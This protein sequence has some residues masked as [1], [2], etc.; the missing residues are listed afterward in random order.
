MKKD[1]T[2]SETTAWRLIKRRSVWLFVGFFIALFLFAVPNLQEKLA[3][4]TQAQR[5]ATWTHAS[6]ALSALIHEL[7]KERGLSSGYLASNGATFSDLMQQQRLL[8]DHALSTALA[9]VLRTVDNTAGRN[10]LL[11]LN[12]LRELINTQLI[13]RDAQVDRY[14]HMINLL[15][16]H[17]AKTLTSTTTPWPS[18]L[19]FMAFLRAKDMMGLE[20]SLL[21]TIL[22]SRDFGSYARIA[23]FHRI[24]A[25]QATHI[26]QFLQFAEPDA[27]AGYQDILK[28]AFMDQAQGIR[29]HVIAAGH[30]GASDALRLPDPQR[31]FTLSSLGIDAM[32]ALEDIL[33]QSV[34]RKAHAQEAAANTAL[35]VSAISAVAS[36]VLA[37]L[38]LFVVRRGSRVADKGLDLGAAV[39]HNSVEPILI[40]DAN[41]VIVEVNPAFTKTTG[42]TREEALGQHVRM[43][44]S[45]R[46]DAD[47][48]QGM[49]DSI[50]SNN[51][52]EGEIWNRRKNGDLYPA[53]LSIV[54]TRDPAGTVNNY[55]AMTVD[56]SQHKNTE[57]LLNQ[58]RTFDP[59]TNL[60]SRDAWLTALDRAVAGCRSTERGFTVLEIGL[61]RF[62]LVNDS[63]SHAV[64]DQV[65]LEAAERIKGVLRRHDTAARPGGDRF[66]ILL[67]DTVS[68]Q[69]VRTICEKLLAAFVPVFN[70]DEHQLHLSV[71]IGA[72]QYPGD[73]E[74]TSTLQSHAESAMYLAKNEGRA[75]Y[76]F[77][78]AEL[79]AEGARLLSFERLLRQALERS[80]FSLVY[81]P[82]IDARTGCLVGVEALIRW[83]NPELGLISPVQ[84]IPIAEE[85]GLIVSIGEWVMK[86]ACRQAQAWR[87]ELGCDVAVAVNLSA[88]QFRRADVLTTVQAAL[89]ETGLPAHLL[90]LEITEGML[91]TDPQGTAAV[92]HDLRSMGIRLAIDD[93]GTGYSSLAY[94][95]SFP[96]DRLKIDRAFVLGLPDDVSDCAIARAVIALGH[97]LNMEIL[98]EGVETQAQNDFLANAGCHVIQ[99]YYYSKPLTADTLLAH[100][101]SGQLK[102]A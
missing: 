61:D 55:I 96:L 56:L 23:S 73:G 74:K 65:L 8:T 95:K 77:Y 63:L 70:I 31:W 62:K 25:V 66:S 85:T 71:S 15:L 97:N 11:R 81:Q 27:V 94:L 98:A 33:S 22:S 2:G 86:T 64:G 100:V 46:H 42:F 91:M 26:A 52:W 12:D 17:M 36:F 16:A 67:E 39:F 43:L 82:Q 19:A 9:D 28:Q 80:E 13:S 92:L 75:N 93:F 79:D 20:R 38:L 49:W 60:L 37:G 3:E 5:T 69:D 53:L 99:G 88:R 40:T 89:T 18:Q 35:M 7:Q 84:F 83:N 68:L 21:T 72:A 78:S 54:A 51:S 76:K 102:L 32:K 4:R 101:R 10:D 45:G 47:F 34:L 58:L 59:L 14:N 90:E 1:S 44:K 29:R 50:Q 24:N 41:S 6:V 57:D 87:T 30:S 48:Y